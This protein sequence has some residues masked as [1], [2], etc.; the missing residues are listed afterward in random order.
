[1]DQNIDL[2]SNQLC[3]VVQATKFII[4]RETDDERERI[5]K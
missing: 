3:V 1:M 4:T 2:A 5:L